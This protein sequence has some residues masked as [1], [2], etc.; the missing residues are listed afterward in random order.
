ME[1]LLGQDAPRGRPYGGKFTNR[2]RG[3]PLRPSRGSTTSEL[4][5]GGKFTNRGGGGPLRPSRGSPSVDGLPYGGK[6][7]RRSRSWKRGRGLSQRPWL[8]EYMRL[9]V[10]SRPEANSR[11]ISPELSRN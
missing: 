6:F 9:G 1:R 10:G 7:T 5:Y 8:Q 11:C 3:G 4:P 2:G